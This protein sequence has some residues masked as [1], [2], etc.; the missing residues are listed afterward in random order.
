MSNPSVRNLVKKVQLIPKP[1]K[2]TVQSHIM[3]MNDPTTAQC[4]MEQ[5][6]NQAV[7]NGMTTQLHNY[8]TEC[9]TE[10]L[11]DN[12][13]SNMLSV[14]NQ[15]SVN[16]TVPMLVFQYK[17]WIFHKQKWEFKIFAFG[18]KMSTLNALAWCM[19]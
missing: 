19:G 1:Q 5:P 12:T 10:W 2:C 15:S 14:W 16:A 11:H 18:K 8:A 7:W 9:S 13:A 3:K 6:H 4:G 17:I